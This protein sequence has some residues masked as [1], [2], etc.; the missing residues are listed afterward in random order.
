MS[1][2]V[3]SVNRFSRHLITR[4]FNIWIN[5]SDVVAKMRLRPV[6]DSTGFFVISHRV[7]Q[8]KHGKLLVINILCKIG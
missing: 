3:T 5:N 2:M 7:V 6:R 8:L 4:G 1:D